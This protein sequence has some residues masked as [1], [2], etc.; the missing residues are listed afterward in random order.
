MSAPQLPF[1]QLELAGTVGLDEGRYLARDPERVL[2]VRVAGAPQ[3]PR[4]LLRKPRPKDVAPASEPPTVPITTITVIRADP[5]GDRDAAERW[6]DALRRDENALEAELAD[7]LRTA[8]L[9]L[10]A[11]RI[12]SLDPFLADIAAEHALAVRI[13]FGEGEALADGQWTEAVELPKGVRRRRLETLAPQEK[14]ASVLGRREDPDAATGALLRARADVDAE[15]Y[16]DAALQVRVG[17]EAML[18]DK[19][20]TANAKQADD[21]AALTE[22]RQ[23]LGECA[24]AALQG[25]LSEERRQELLETLKLAERVLRRRRAYG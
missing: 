3:P 22:R 13:G 7:G 8:N 6:L 14:I 5:L 17:V 1:V 2:V 15:R 20:F 24:N 23:G 12:A 18:A 16:R 9:A 21:I 10:H 19:A 25:E 4:R 11:Q